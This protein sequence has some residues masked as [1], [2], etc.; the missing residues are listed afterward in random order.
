MRARA[1]LLAGLLLA[2]PTVASST[3]THVFITSPAS[4]SV[5]SGIVTLTGTAD[6]ASIIDGV[7][8][9]FGSEPAYNA[10]LGAVS[11][12]TVAW[13]YVVDTQLMPDGKIPVWAQTVTSGFSNVTMINL[14]LRNQPAIAMASPAQSTVVSGVVP[15]SGTASSPYTAL[16]GV[17][18]GPLAGPLAPA[19]V[20]GS[21][22][23]V[24]WSGS[25]D[26]TT[27][28]NGPQTL[29]AVVANVLGRTTGVSRSVIVSN[30]PTYDLS[31][32]GVVGSGQSDVLV[33]LRNDGNSRTSGFDVRLEYGSGGDWVP[34]A[35]VRT[36]VPGFA[37]ATVKVAYVPTSGLVGTHTMRA[38]AD[39]GG[40]VG[41]LDETDNTGVGAVTFFTSLVTLPP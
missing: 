29:R 28:P 33:T 20:S 17:Q 8:V 30:P 39:A 37:T 40:V 27:L 3:P 7:R 19:T 10:T 22:T 31:V 38:T 11:G 9:Y 25:V 18:V 13:T 41:E 36:S 24:S 34:Y 32:D 6:P 1:V 12:T 14:T 23:S 21:T 2:V 5:V 15:V 4:G 35:T 16:A 26:T